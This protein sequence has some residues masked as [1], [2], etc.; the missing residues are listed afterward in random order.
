MVKNQNQEDEVFTGRVAHFNMDKGYGFIKDTTCNEKYFFHITDAFPEINEGNIVLFEL[1]S[2]DSG[3]VA[4][5]I[6]LVQ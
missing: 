3:T 1:E 5:K 2:G 4:M 6:T